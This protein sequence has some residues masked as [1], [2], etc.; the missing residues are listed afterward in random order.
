MIGSKTERLI[1]R[2]ASI[3]GVCVKWD[4]I[5]K[6]V[7]VVAVLWFG[8]TSSTLS[9]QVLK[10]EAVMSANGTFEVDLTPQEDVGSPAG[11]M[12]IKKTYLGDMNGSGI[13]QM[14]SKSTEAGTAVYYAIEEFSGSVKGKTGRFTLVHKGNMS[15]ESQ[16]LEVTILEGSG[17]GELQNISG[18]MLI[19]QDAN[20]HKYELTFEL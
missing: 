15:K 4:D 9:V 20:G 8:L 16:S 10:E 6:Q 3:C 1:L 2:E 5:V 19:I 11:R 13:G 7:L 12:L 17:S 18:S 14:I